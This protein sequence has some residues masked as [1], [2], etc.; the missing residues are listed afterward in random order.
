[1]WLEVLPLC[2]FPLPVYA[3]TE[4]YLVMFF[5]FYTLNRRLFSR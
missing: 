4:M 2:L 3:L 1:M 5:V